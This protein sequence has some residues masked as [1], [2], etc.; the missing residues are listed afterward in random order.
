MFGADEHPHPSGR[1]FEI[2]FQEQAVT[3]VEVGGGLRDYTAGGSE[4]L[5]GYSLNEPCG[6]GRGQLLLPWPNRIQDGSYRFAG[7]EQR[8]PLTEPER[9]NAIH[10]LGRWS[11]WSVADHTQ[12][13][14]TMRLRLF[15]QP[16]YPFLLDLETIYVLDEAGLSVRMAATN[17]GDESC[18]F[19]AGAHPYL[20][21]GGALVDDC[22]LRLPAAARLT[23]DGRG[24]PT[25]REPLAG[26]AWDFRRP[27]PIDDLELDTAFTEL[28]AGTDGVARVELTSPPAGRTVTLWAEAEAFPYLMV[29]SG[30]TL[31]AD[32][33]R[34]G[35]AVEPM[36]CPPNAFQ[37]GESL[38]VLEPGESW[39]GAWGI[40]PG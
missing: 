16:G 34:R 38:I 5:D 14:V 17:L 37:S 2:R 1:Q 19:G 18:P 22:L 11:S 26:T 6:G 30:D 20:H 3:V 12:A 33:R 21:A 29:F 40:S 4:V 35:L 32:R 15:P 39:S 23:A 24:I 13:A 8:L 27:R 9:G 10:G 25:G 28:A 31:A 36:T 7:A